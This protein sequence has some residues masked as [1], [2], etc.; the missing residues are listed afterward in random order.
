[1]ALKISEFVIVYIWHIFKSFLTTVLEINHF[2]I[3]KK[4]IFIPLSCTVFGLEKE[5]ETIPDKLLK[6]S[7]EKVLRTRLNIQNII[8][9]NV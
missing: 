5:I 6:G 7:S 1:M 4:K 9:F 2:I 8:F 3:K